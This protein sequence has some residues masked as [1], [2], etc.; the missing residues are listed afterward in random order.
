MTVTFPA[1]AAV[2]LY[3]LASKMPFSFVAF[4]VVAFASVVAAVEI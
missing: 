1:R 2:S 4:V 3:I